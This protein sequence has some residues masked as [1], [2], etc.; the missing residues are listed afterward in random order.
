MTT[1]RNNVEAVAR[2][3][4]ERICRDEGKDETATADWVDL[5]WP[6]VAA[7]LE[8]GLIDETGTRLTEWTIDRSL[9]ALRDWQQRHPGEV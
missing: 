1:L 6:Y 8:A 9:A 7:E 5:H 4:S 3:I 2:K